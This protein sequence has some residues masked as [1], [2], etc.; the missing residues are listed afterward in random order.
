MLQA[1]LLIAGSGPAL[2]QCPF[3]GNSDEIPA[4]HE[5]VAVRP[6]AIEGYQEAV[7][8][9]DIE[10]VKADIL[11]V[12]TT[13]VASWPADYGTYAPFMIRLAWHCA[14]SYRQDDGV[15]GCDGGRI[16]LDEERSWG[17]NANLDKARMLLRPIKLKYGLGL[18]WGDLIILAGNVAIESMGGPLLGTCLGR[19]DESSNYWA[20]ELGPNEEQRAVA[21]CDMGDTFCTAPFGA[22]ETSIIY[23]N[24][25]GPGGNGTD[26]LGSAAHIRSS[27]GRMSMNDTETVAL[28]GGGHAFGKGH[29]ACPDGAGPSPAE[30]P[31]N[32]WPGLCGD[33]ISVEDRFTSGWEG[34]WTETPVNWTNLYFQYLSTFDFTLNPFVNPAGN[35]VWRVPGNAIVAPTANLS[36]TEP[37]M[38]YTSDVSLQIDS[39]YREIVDLFAADLEYLEE[40]FAS[41]WY[42]LTTRDMGPVTRCVGSDTPPA[43]D[44]Q[45][46]LPDPPATLPDYDAVAQMISETVNLAGAD[47]S[48]L[49]RYSVRLA[50]R[51]ASTFRITDYRGGCNGARILLSPEADWPIN[52]GL[53]DVAALLDPIKAAY[54]DLSWSDLIVLAGTLALE[55]HG[56]NALPFCGGRTDASDG[57]G[58][59]LLEPRLTFGVNDT[60]TEIKYAIKL[61]GLTE[62]EYI[63]LL[64]LNAI[65]QMHPTLTTYNGTASAMLSSDYFTSA[66]STSWISD[67]TQYVS[68][69]GDLY[70][71]ST[72]AFLRF[73]EVLGHYA[74]IYADDEAEFKRSLATA[75]TKLMSIERSL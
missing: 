31:T 54:D 58:S 32:P 1:L 67:G 51:C 38:M 29:G 34:T 37:V 65:G 44:F 8:A 75:W 2:A 7:E 55:M 5:V 46:P 73:D 45:F 43:Q 64:G 23:V 72:T 30:D 19:V 11:D 49:A 36:A 16:R 14:G 20:V 10:A 68:P 42:K 33:G 63:A 15:G 48:A 6:V 59:D 17:D 74:E 53:A 18:S 21:P 4:G 27:F 61:S 56:S 24:P 13:S 62:G 69:E 25:G 3:A 50:W 40:Q 35:T 70:A 71:L 41:A 47:G 26:F 39:A 66:L 52:A 60:E 28:I 12:L 57:A 9:L 22:T